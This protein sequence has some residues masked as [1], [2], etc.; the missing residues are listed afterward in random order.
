MMA[1]LMM[2]TNVIFL[3][4]FLTIYLS[5]LFL[6]F[7]YSRL[8]LSMSFL[9]QASALSLAIGA[10]APRSSREVTSLPAIS[11]EHK[12]VFLFG[13]PY[14][15][16]MAWVFLVVIVA[17]GLSWQKLVFVCNVHFVYPCLRTRVFVWGIF[18]LVCLCVCL[19]VCVLWQVCG[20]YQVTT[21]PDL[22]GKAIRERIQTLQ[23]LRII[24]S[25]KLPRDRGTG[26]WQSI[27]WMLF[28]LFTKSRVIP[29][30]VGHVGSPRARNFIWKSQSPKL[31]SDKHKW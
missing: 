17:N 14:Q 3:V 25:D 7:A 27:L 18:S 12:I 6:L 21:K 5:M 19:C 23:W 22:W 31:I 11:G 30:Q 15:V 24:F 26:L 4:C 1:M 10:V 16:T 13:P 2:T 8:Y 20:K 28:C 29:I 9:S